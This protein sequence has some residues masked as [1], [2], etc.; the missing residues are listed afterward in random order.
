MHP[1]LETSTH[2][3]TD[4]QLCRSNQA[5]CIDLHLVHARNHLLYRSQG[6]AG[7]GRAGQGRAGQ[8]RA[9]QGRGSSTVYRRHNSRR[10]GNT[11]Y[12]TAQHDTAQ[13]GTAQH[14]TA[15]DRAGQGSMQ[16]QGNLTNPWPSC[17]TWCSS[18]ARNFCSCCSF[19]CFSC[20]WL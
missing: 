15:Q 17:L 11:A 8:G 16:H 19:C 9:G 4:S 18:L 5:E 2:A 20:D 12:S 1:M 6:R 7:Q 10:Q 14:S 3:G 13:H